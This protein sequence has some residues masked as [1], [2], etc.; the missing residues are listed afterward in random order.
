M[1]V[2]FLSNYF[3]TDNV[4]DV[5]FNEWLYGIHR[6]KF[7]E[8]G[9]EV[10]NGLSDGVV[11]VVFNYLQEN[12]HH[13]VEDF[14]FV[15][16]ATQE[17]PGPNLNPKALELVT[18]VVLTPFNHL[19]DNAVYCRSLQPPNISFYNGPKSK[20]LSILVS[21]RRGLLPRGSLYEFRHELVRRIIESDLDCDVYGNWEH[22]GI[23]DDRLKGWTDDRAGAIYPYRRSIAIENSR[24]RGYF[25]EKP[26][27]CLFGGAQVLYYG[28]PSAK[29]AYGE[30]IIDLDIDD[31]IGQLR[32]LEGQ[33][34]DVEAV[35]EAVK[36]HLDK[37]SLPVVL[38]R[39]FD[40]L[41]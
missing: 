12:K 16:G 27:N 17:P 37:F 14:P 11:P 35:G 6:D 38:R 5:R 24:H 25:T 23:N 9:V 40:E 36:R 4:S 41:G 34:V 15:I 3:P 21:S 7:D 19:F 10:T 26:L 22:L 18:D 30:A 33:P 13:L 32:W 2:F 28:D 31:P 39:T 29:E 20:N 8:V 1:K